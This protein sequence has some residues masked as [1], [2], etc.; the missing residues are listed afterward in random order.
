M[1]CNV[2]KIA[3]NNDV[4]MHARVGYKYVSFFFS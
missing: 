2:D 4:N 3:N 1:I